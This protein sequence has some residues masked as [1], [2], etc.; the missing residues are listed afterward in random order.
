MSDRLTEI[1]ERHVELAPPA[2][3][4]V[5]HRMLTAFGLAVARAVAE[6]AA[7]ALEEFIGADIDCW[8]EA[9]D[10]IRAHFGLEVDDAE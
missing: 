9:A 6:E 3:K 2:T 4:L 7:S 1:V 10:E 8:S 5:H